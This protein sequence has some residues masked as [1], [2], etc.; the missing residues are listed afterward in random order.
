MD[1]VGNVELVTIQGLTSAIDN[2][3]GVT[4]VVSVTDFEL[5]TE[6]LLI[7]RVNGQQLFYFPIG[8]VRANANSGKR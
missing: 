3:V 4:G 1:E 7:I 2:G 6:E 5:K 8:L